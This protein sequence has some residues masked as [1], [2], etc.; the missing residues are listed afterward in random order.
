VNVPAVNAEG[1]AAASP[2]A[3]TTLLGEL[4]ENAQVGVLAVDS[5]RYVAANVFA[6]EIT[7][8]ERAELIGKGVEV[9]CPPDAHDHERIGKRLRDGGV[10]VVKL[11]CKDGGEIEVIFRVAPTSVAQMQLTVALFALF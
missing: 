9:L 11:R 8:Y 7:G 10:G 2:L 5:G 1:S 6:C 3:Q 4:L